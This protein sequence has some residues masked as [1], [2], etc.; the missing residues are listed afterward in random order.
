MLELFILVLFLSSLIFLFN[1]FLQSKALTLK[2]KTVELYTSIYERAQKE[3]KGEAIGFGYTGCKDITVDAFD[4]FD[5]LDVSFVPRENTRIV[6]VQDFAETFASF[7]SVGAST[8]LFMESKENF[9]YLLSKVAALPKSTTFGGN[10]PH[11]ALRAAYENF[12]AVVIA[13]IGQEEVSTIKALDSLSKIRFV[14]VNEGRETSDVHLIFEYPPVEYK[15]VKAP[16]AN[17]FYLNHDTISPKLPALDK[18]LSAAVELN[19]S[20]HAL[21]GF[22]LIQKLPAGDSIELLHR[23]RTQWE[24]LRK[25]GKQT[26]HMEMGA[27]QNPKVYQAVI[28][29]LLLR[30]DSVGIN[31]QEILVLH[32]FLKERDFRTLAVPFS[33]PSLLLTKVFEIL[34]ILE[35]R[36]ATLSR[37]HIHAKSMHHL[38][39]RDDLWS[40][41]LYT[42][43]SPR[44]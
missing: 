19:L 12:D 23:V 1:K 25:R 26:I 28:E 44:D 4:L 29:N 43:P 16:K 35:E 9:D 13:D 2:R 39:Y 3:E 5:K 33:D 32:A 10:A 21:S 24:Q 14:A 31:E 42:S 6:T 40:C 36:K 18:Y 17:K 30:A 34:E 15:G 27:F 22:H 41:L 7:F 8:E 11:M 38:C 20:K 37:F